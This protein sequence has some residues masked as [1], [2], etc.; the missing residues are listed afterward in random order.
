MAFALA[1]TR[2][3]P[4]Y[5]WDYLITASVVYMSHTGALC[6][7]EAFLVILI[8]RR[9]RTCPV[10]GVLMRRRSA[11]SVRTT[12]STSA[13]RVASVLTGNLLMFRRSICPL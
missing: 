13:V 3:S 4:L 11:C 6:L 12:L 5:R 9:L 2:R 10:G 7:A 1:R 8:V